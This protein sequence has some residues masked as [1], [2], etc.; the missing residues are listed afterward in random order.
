M[1]LTIAQLLD[2]LLALIIVMF[3]PIG[4]WRGALREWIALVGI[5]LAGAL[6]GEWAYPWGG[7][8]AT[9]AALDPRVARFA[10]GALVPLT[11]TLLVGYGA[12]IALPFR[13]DLTWPNRA[14]GAAVALGN[15]LLILSSALRVMQHNL[16]DD[17]PASPL[18]GSALAQ[19]LIDYVGWALLAQALVLAG[20]VGAG[21][22]RR[23]TGGAP[24]LEEYAA[25]HPAYYGAPYDERYGEFEEDLVAPE[26]VEAAPGVVWQPGTQSAAHDLA[27]QDTAVLRPV[28]PP[29]DVREIVETPAPA[30]EPAG[31][32]APPVPAEEPPQPVPAR[33][34]V[35]LARPPA[36]REAGPPPASPAAATVPAEPTPAAGSNGAT[37]HPGEPAADPPAVAVCANC[38]TTISARSRVC[39]TC[40]HLIG[41][42]ERRPL[43]AT[44]ND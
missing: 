8:L 42:A 30:A 10:V 5:L 28:A 40:G 33:R 16:F 35:E 18:L 38:G 36:R 44:K 41:D 15:G 11:V 39:P 20:S 13:P 12:G 2:L 7:D 24:L 23:W 22:L 43:R 31:E 37:P 34:V 21:A 9:E 1:P 4:L 19:F 3:I 25:R 17:D 26:L 6:A 29:V 32:A 27:A 14:L